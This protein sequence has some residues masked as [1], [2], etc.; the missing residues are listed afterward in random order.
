MSTKLSVNLV[1]VRDKKFSTW[2]TPPERGAEHKEDLRKLSGGHMEK[3]LIDKHP[4]ISLEDPNNRE[5]ETNF[6]FKAHKKYK[7]AMD[8]Q[9]GEAICIARVFAKFKDRF[10]RIN[11]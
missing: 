1:G 2:G 3:H 7:F 5:A 9:L 4:D 6:N 8:R 11:I 10:K